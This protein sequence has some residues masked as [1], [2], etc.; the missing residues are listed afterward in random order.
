[1]LRKLA[2]FSAFIFLIA[3]VCAGVTK[4]DPATISFNHDI[5]P[6]FSEH[7]YA[8]HGPDEGKRKAGLRLD[9]EESALKELKSGAH[10]IV[11]GDL[12][13][14]ALIERIHSTDPDEKM[15]P[16]KS[17]KPLNKE[18]IELLTRWVQ[19]GAKWQN[20]WSFI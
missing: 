8:C 10:A 11:P 1:M 18:Q 17:G 20:H 19:Q 9:S 14:S 13:K 7:C 16:V 3:R 6:I 5:R 4:S 2:R 12:K 15:P